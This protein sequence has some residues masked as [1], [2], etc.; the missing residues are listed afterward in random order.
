MDF[1]GFVKTIFNEIYDKFSKPLNCSN[2]INFKCIINVILTIIILY[3]LYYIVNLIIEIKEKNDNT[4]N[5]NTNNDNTNNDNI[6]YLI[7][8]FLLFVILIIILFIY[9]MDVE[10]YKKLINIFKF[11][12]N[13]INNDQNIN[14]QNINDQI[15]IDQNDN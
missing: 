12:R 3:N 10:T 11:N 14:D 6:K 7:L 8:S 1:M 13:Q 2:G 9:N 5:D 15:N 4:N